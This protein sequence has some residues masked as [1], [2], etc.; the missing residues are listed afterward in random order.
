MEKGDGLG[1]L[2]ALAMPWPL[3]RWG[4]VDS[5]RGEGSPAVAAAAWRAGGAPMLPGTQRVPVQRCREQGTRGGA[6]RGVCAPSRCAGK[7]AEYPL[8]P[9]G[10]P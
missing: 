1:A 4:A 8:V 10:S 2:L 9:A 5:S 3:T 6:W 7:Q